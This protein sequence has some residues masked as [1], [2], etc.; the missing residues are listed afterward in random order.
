MK[1][2]REQWWVGQ[3]TE[4]ENDFKQN[5][6]GDFFKKMKR[7]SG[8]KVTPADTILDKSGQPLKRNE[9]KLAR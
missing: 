8:N 2:D 9:E 3:L 5:R 7:L 6:Q 4:M 1:C